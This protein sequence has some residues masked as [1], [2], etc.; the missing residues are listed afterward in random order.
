MHDAVS[1]RIAAMHAVG[2]RDQ[3]PEALEARGRRWS[4]SGSSADSGGATVRQ[5]R[6]RGP[7]ELSLR[8]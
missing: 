7:A 4:A 1:Q 3:R 8:E 2:A 5:R 6:W